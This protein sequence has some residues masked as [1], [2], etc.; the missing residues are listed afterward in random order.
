MQFCLK[1]LGP[2]HRRY[3]SA[4]S[5]LFDEGSSS[6]SVEAEPLNIWNPLLAALVHH[7]VGGVLQRVL[8]DGDLGKVALTCHFAC[9][10][11]CEEMYDM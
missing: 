4:M 10:S 2:K 8:S 3:L 5:T 9:D 11:L 7:G 6:S 1:R